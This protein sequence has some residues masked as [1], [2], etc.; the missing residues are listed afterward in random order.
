MVRKI[1]KL[2]LFLLACVLCT[3]LPAGVTFA[4][5]VSPSYKVN[6]TFFGTGGNLD[7]TSAHYI[8]KTAAGELAV[9]NISSPHF[10]AYAGFNTT[11][12]VLLEMNVTGGTF[13]MGV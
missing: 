4:Q 13:D 6:E 2:K 10:Q 7:N 9:G 1:K 8:A 5:Y 11:N 12:T 3:L